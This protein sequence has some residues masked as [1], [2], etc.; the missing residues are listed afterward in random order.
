M[1]SLYQVTP[2]ALVAGGLI[3]AVL[4]ARRNRGSGA[5]GGP[6]GSRGRRGSDKH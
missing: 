6:G 3:A 4:I 2:F 5:P 1:Q